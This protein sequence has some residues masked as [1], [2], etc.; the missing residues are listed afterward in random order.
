MY[1]NAGPARIPHHHKAILGYCKE[2]D[3]PLEVMVNDNRATFFQSDDAFEGKP[4]SS[5]AVIHDTR[6]FIAELLAKAIDKNAL[7]ELISGEDKKR[8]SA[9]VRSFGDLAKDNTYKGSPRAGYDEPPGA[10]LAAGRLREPLSF[11]ELLKSD[12]WY[13]K[14][15]YGEHFERRLRCY[16]RSVAWIGS[17]VRSQSASAHRSRMVLLS[18]RYASRKPVPGL[19]ATIGAVENFQLRVIMRVHHSVGGS[20]GDQ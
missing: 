18:R 3:V 10:E 15:Y 9:F 11:K 14:L 16:S 17:R 13:Y 6:G 19:Y 20:S 1:F 8:M 2:F 5:R 4:V 7:A 12:F